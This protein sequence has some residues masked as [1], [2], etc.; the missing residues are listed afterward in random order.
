M[1]KVEILS[2]SWY[3]ISTKEEADRL[4]AAGGDK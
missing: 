1:T 2:T 4:E 3:S